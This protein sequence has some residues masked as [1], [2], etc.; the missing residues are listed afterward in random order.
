MESQ[1]DYLNGWKIKDSQK[2]KL[3]RIIERILEK[4]AQDLVVIDLRPL[5]TGIADFFVIAT[6]FT[7]DHL[8]AMALALNDILEPLHEEGLRTKWTAL[9]YFDIIVHLMTP[10]YREYY[11]LEGLWAAAPQKKIDEED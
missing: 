4:N 11:D 5:N 6:G 9:D 8:E 3:N 1:K 10:D 2:Q 7:E